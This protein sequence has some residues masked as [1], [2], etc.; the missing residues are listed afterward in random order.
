MLT[1]PVYNYLTC[2]G[3]HHYEAERCQNVCL[4]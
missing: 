1:N 2:P 3:W 4:H